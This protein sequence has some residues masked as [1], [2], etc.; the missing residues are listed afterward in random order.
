MLK[1]AIGTTNP[2]KVQAIQ[3]AFQEQ[4]GEVQFQ[5]M[6]TESYVSEQPLSD[7]ETI[8]G[9]INRAK[10]VL[11]VTDSDIGIGLEGGVS[12]ALYGMF[13]CNW[14]ALVDRQGNEII[15][16]GARISLPKEISMELKAG[17]ELG[18][19]MDEYTQRTGIRKKEGAIGVFTNGL[20]TREAMFLHVVEL[21][22]GQWQYK[23]N[24]SGK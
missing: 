12:E 14:G 20:I 18:P 22:I 8:E 13:V 23:T 16:G 7:Q 21:L 15:G 4:Y 5:C 3:K 1:V 6:K 10:N 11:K 2:A 24:L 9:A 19:L 17:K